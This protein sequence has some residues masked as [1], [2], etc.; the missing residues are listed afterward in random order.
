MRQRN[1]SKAR[2]NEIN[3][4]NVLDRPFKLLLEVLNSFK[5]LN[6]TDPA[7]L[8]LSL[9]GSVGHFAGEWTVM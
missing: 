3:V 6:D 2:D 1:L 9:F 4:E 8:L 7:G 5:L